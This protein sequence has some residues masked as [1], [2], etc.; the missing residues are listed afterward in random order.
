MEGTVGGRH[1]DPPQPC[2]QVQKE[3]GKPSLCLS[4][5][6]AYLSM[7]TIFFSPSLPMLFYTLVAG[8]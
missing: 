8:S 1:A 4:Q 3:D 5:A 2:D 7:L 6:R